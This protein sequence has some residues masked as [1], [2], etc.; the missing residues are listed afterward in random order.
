[1]KLV[2]PLNEISAGGKGFIEGISTEM[3]QYS[4]ANEE[5]LPDD[6][7][8]PVSAVVRHQSR[9]KQRH[10]RKLFTSA[11]FNAKRDSAG[12]KTRS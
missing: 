9:K 4:P 8:N 12:N 1:M 7:I 6:I 11:S 5:I 3:T 2:S 10:K